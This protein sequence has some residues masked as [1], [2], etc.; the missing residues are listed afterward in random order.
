MTYNYQAPQNEINIPERV[1]DKKCP[2]VMVLPPQPCHQDCKANQRK[3]WELD[4]IKLTCIFGVGQGHT[5]AI[6]NGYTVHREHSKECTELVKT[7]HRDIVVIWELV[8]AT[9]L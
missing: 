4:V 3:S 6:S 8:S 5:N 9:I 1:C 2:G 7:K